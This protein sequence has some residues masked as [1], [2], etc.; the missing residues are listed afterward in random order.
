[1]ITQS[2]LFATA[3][4][5]KCCTLSSLKPL[6][7]CFCKKFKLCLHGGVSLLVAELLST[8]LINSHRPNTPATRNS[9]GMNTCM[10]SISINIGPLFIEA[11]S[12]SEASSR[13]PGMRIG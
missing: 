4:K 8:N 10:T 3:I 11:G 5:A 12:S 9:Q 1:M 6:A 7:Y 13:G 2:S